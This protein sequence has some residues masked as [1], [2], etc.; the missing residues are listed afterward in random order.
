MTTIYDIAKKVGVSATT[1]SKAIN[2]CPGVSKKTREKVDAAVRE[3]DYHPNFTAKSLITKH[4]GLIGI[5]FEECEG[6]WLEHE[7][8]SAVITGLN[9]AVTQKGYE[10]L[11]LNNRHDDANTGGTYLQHCRRRGVEAVFIATV[12]SFSDELRELIDSEIPCVAVDMDLPTVPVVTS[13]NVMGA[14][15]AVEYLI[16]QGHRNIAYLAAPL[17]TIEGRERM[18]GYKDALNESGIIFRPELV[19]ECVDFNYDAGAEAIT[20]LLERTT[21]FTAIFCGCDLCAFAAIVGCTAKGLRV[22]KDV[23]VVGFDD[24]LQAKCYNPPLT[25]VRQYR[26]ILGQTA[27][28]LLLDA[29][30]G[31]PAKPDRFIVPTELVVRNSVDRI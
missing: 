5:V 7:H 8:F 3:L 12:T 26:S 22:P 10:L 11:F 17:N 6:L 19:E 21:D 20:A 14:K 9:D 18:Q 24:I 13:G 4:S 28:R 30:N 27:A 29:I 1:V 15:R 2:N 25:T 16:E 23:S 31:N